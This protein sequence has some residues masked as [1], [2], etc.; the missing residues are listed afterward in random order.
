MNPLTPKCFE[1]FSHHHKD[2]D[3]VVEQIKQLPPQ[4]WQAAT[5]KFDECFNLVGV[6]HPTKE[7]NQRLYNANVWLR[8]T[9]KKHK[10]RNY[11][12]ERVD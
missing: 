9:V 11:Q 5:R 8:E 7:V 1:L 3:W 10:V 2:S 4:W 6:Y 12:L